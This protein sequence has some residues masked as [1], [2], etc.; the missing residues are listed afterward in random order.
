M[1]MAGTGGGPLVERTDLRAELAAGTPP[2]CPQCG[3]ESPAASDGTCPTCG[4][5]RPA[6]RDHVELVLGDAAA[7]T[8][9]GL[10]RR[11]NEDAVELGRRVEGSGEDRVE[12]WVAVVCD[13]VASARRGDE[14]SLAAVGAAVG[15]ALETAAAPATPPTGFPAIS[16]RDTGPVSTESGEPHDDATPTTGGR[17]GTGVSGELDALATAASAAAA[18]AAADLGLGGGDS[19]ACTYVAAVV[20]GGEAVVSWIGDSRAY[21]LAGDGSSRLLSTDDS[22]A[23]EI[24]NAGI[25][26]REEAAR[27]RR[28]HVLTRWLGRDAPSGP[29]HARRVRIGVPGVLLL[30][31]DGLWNHLPD[32]EV[33]ARLARPALGGTSAAE[34]VD[35]DG[36]PDHPALAAAA[37]LLAAAL[38]DGGHDNATLALIPVTPPP[39]AAGRPSV[40]VDGRGPDE[41]TGPIPL[42]GEGVVDR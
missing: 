34:N 30:C 38:D 5:A 11:R 40:T 2:P 33:L 1:E 4:A 39:G 9:R 15:A 18:T 16:S 17:A 29:A 41:R 42:D 35:P 19:P 13:G 31:S 36:V 7:I 25:M 10:R 24:A 22:W 20:R 6:L 21:W 37:A 27:D 32:P 12:T 26:S 23:E 3:D 8:D 28:A 14:A